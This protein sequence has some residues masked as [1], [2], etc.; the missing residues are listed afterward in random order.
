MAHRNPP[1]KWTGLSPRLTVRECNIHPLGICYS[2]RM[3]LEKRVITIISTHNPLEIM[4]WVNPKGTCVDCIKI[5]R[6]LK[7]IDGVQIA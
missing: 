2:V 7:N 1:T 5:C 3:W 4:S 6:G